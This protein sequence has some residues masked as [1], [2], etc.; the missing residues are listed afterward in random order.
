MIDDFVL[1]FAATNAAC[2]VSGWFYEHFASYSSWRRAGFL[3]DSD[4]DTMTTFQNCCLYFFITVCGIML[5]FY[6]NNLCHNAHCNF[7]RKLPAKRNSD[8]CMDFVQLL[9]SV[10]FF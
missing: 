2:N 9:Q 10:T 7:L 1:Y 6:L 3:C 8:W 4:H 5:I